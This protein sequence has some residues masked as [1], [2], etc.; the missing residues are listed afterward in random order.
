MTR[1]HSLRC[2]LP[3]VTLAEVALAPLSAHAA[4]ITKL[5]TG[6]DLTAGAGWSYRTFR[7]PGTVP[8]D[9]KAFLR[10]KISE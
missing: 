5:A 8:V 4:V 1:K 9:P 6:T 7:A 10:A 2:L 3:A